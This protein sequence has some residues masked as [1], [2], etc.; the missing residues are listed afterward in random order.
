MRLSA[1]A[2]AFLLIFSPGCTRTGE[3]ET[4]TAETGTAAAPET[5]EVTLASGGSLSCRVVRGVDATDLEIQAAVSIRQGL[6][7][8][9]PGST[10]PIGDDLAIGSGH[11]PD[12]VE[13]LVGRTSYDETAA[14]A[15]EFGLGNAVVTL[16]GNKIVVFSGIDTAMPLLASNFLSM[17]TKLKN[18]GELVFRSSDIYDLSVSSQLSA[19]PDP[20]TGGTPRIV[21]AGDKAYQIFIP[22]A[23]GQTLADYAEKLSSAGFEK[24]ADRQIGDSRFTTFTGADT[25]VS[26]YYTGYNNVVRIV[27]EPSRNL[28]GGSGGGN[29]VTSP[30]L[31]MIGREYTSG[32]KYMGTDANSGLMCFLIR[33]SDGRFIVI[34]GGTQDGKSSYASAIY[35]KMLEQA[36]DPKNI[37]IAAWFFSHTHSDHIG[38]FI[39]FG[40]LYSGRVK[41]ESILLNFPSEADNSAASD[42]PATMQLFSSAA[43]TNFPKTPVYKLHTGQNF[44]ISDAE[45]NVWYTHEDFVTKTRSV[46][47]VKNNWNNTSL[48]FSVDIAG[49]RIMFLGDSQQIPNDLT[50]A[51]FGDALKSDIVQVA[52]HGGQGGTK[53]IYKAIDPEV[54]LFTTSDEL[55]PVYISNF[56]YNSYLVSGLHLKEYFNAAARITVFRLPYSAKGSGFISSTVN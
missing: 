35:A 3:D 46:A 44:I 32:N 27:A 7:D 50:A 14:V 47:T 10:L 5:N 34:D 43:K 25:A 51:I 30:L 49:Q 39:S 23:T 37:V 19:I 20:G 31:T 54:A 52:H 53:S 12:A 42:S 18:D 28:Y 2:S 24:T 9:F 48:I 11:D 4:S 21:D 1:L 29:A 8:L 36:P 6:L 55:L 22:S 41:L 15:A 56:D 45:I 33:L 16:R 38:G 26:A 17:A 40:A 13:I